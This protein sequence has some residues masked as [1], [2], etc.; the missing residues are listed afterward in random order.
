MSDLTHRVAFR[1][2]EDE[3]Y[4]I[5]DQAAEAGFNVSEYLLWLVMN[6]ETPIRG[7]DMNLKGGEK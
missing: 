3:F 1:C 5:K 2:T 4:N 6:D 7:D